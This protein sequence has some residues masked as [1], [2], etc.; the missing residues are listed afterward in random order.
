MIWHAICP[1]L[2]SMGQIKKS[3]K[4][5]VTPI[6]WDSDGNIIQTAFMTFDEDM[7]IIADDYL[8]NILSRYLRHIVTIDGEVFYDGPVKQIRIDRLIF[9]KEV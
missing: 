2:N 3:L 5:I 4:G 8:G 1:C 6:D 7:F 9:E